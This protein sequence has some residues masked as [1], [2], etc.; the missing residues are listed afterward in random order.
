MPGRITLKTRLG[1]KQKAYEESEQ[2]IQTHFR[3]TISERY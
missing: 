2:A 1:I 3:L